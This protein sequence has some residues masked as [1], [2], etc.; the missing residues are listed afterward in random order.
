MGRGIEPDADNKEPRLYNL[1]KE[2]G[3]KTNLAASHPEVV[4][5]MKGLAEKMNSEIGGPKPAAR[6]PA[7]VV[8]NPVILY[9]AERSK[10]KAKN[11]KAMKKAAGG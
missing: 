1:D 10:P 4:A 8:A 7:G 9:P 5:R 6:R 3:E 11:R 2:I